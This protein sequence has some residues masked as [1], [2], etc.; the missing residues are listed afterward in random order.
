MDVFVRATAFNK[1]DIGQNMTSLGGQGAEQTISTPLVD[2]KYTILSQRQHYLSTCALLGQCHFK[3]QHNILY[4]DVVQIEQV[5][6]GC[7]TLL[8][9]VL[10]SDH[11]C[12][13]AI[14]FC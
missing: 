12:R 11:Q 6:L 13:A 10:Q 5:V 7:W 3:R 9:L 2:A 14:S 8:S 4:D 1:F